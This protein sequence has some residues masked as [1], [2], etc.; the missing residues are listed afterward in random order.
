MI[1]N[2]T[3]LIAHDHTAHILGPGVGGLENTMYAYLSS[4]R[5]FAGTSR[6][7]GM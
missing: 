4:Q 6:A 2:I 1:E 3:C 5:P 7:M